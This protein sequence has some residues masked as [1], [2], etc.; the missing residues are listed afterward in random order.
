M[1]CSVRAAGL[2][3][4]LLRLPARFGGRCSGRLAPRQIPAQSK[5]VAGA[6]R[7]CKLRAGILRR[8]RRNRRRLW[9]EVR[10]FG[11]VARPSR[12]PPVERAP[13]GAPQPPGLA[14]SEEHTSELQSLAYLVCRLLLEKKK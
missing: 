9:Q 10:R 4:N 3:R 8:G 2:H 14:R 12:R 6:R 13:P 7:G 5:A 11:T 1:D